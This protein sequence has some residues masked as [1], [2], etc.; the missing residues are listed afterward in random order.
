[1]EE[2]VLHIFLAL[3]VLCFSLDVVLIILSS[4][5]Y[6]R[7]GEIVFRHFSMLFCAILLLL[8]SESF[9]LYEEA[10]PQIIFGDKL[11]VVSAVLSLVGT[12]GLAGAILLI[13]F[14][15]VSMPISARRMTMH[16]VLVAAAAAAG[17]VKEI[18]PRFV[19]TSLNEIVITGIQVYAIIVVLVFFGR[20]TDRRLRSLVQ[21]ILFVAAIMLV[22]TAAELIAA[23][24]SKGLAFLSNYPYVGVAFFLV[25]V[26]LF[27]FY[28]L[29][30]LFQ[31]EPLSGFQLSEDAAR[32]FAISPRERE[33]ISMIVQGLPNRAIGEKLFISSTTVKNHIYHIYRKT[34]VT[35]KIQLINLVNSPK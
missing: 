27:L 5:A 28:A 33:I 19:F 1:M 32:R 24:E 18:F 12:G 20:I 22:G 29:R 15:V 23:T 21:S 14:D 8:V 6:L 26:G 34:G 17:A 11:P 9:K 10:T 2:I 35:N 3:C 16:L 13:A 31:P 30:Y 25:L 4:L 7:S